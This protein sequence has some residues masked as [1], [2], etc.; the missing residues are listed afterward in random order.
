MCEKKIEDKIL[1]LIRGDVTDVETDAFVYH[2][3][4]NLELG[5]GFGGAIAVRGGP[6][7]KKELE[8]YLKENSELNVGDAIIS[9]AGN[10]KA[11]YIIHA[12]GPKFQE[13]NIKEKLSTTIL[14]AL[15]STAEKKDI[16]K[17][18]FPPLG[19]GFYGVPLDL[20]ADVLLTTVKQYLETN[21]TLK[22][23]EVVLQDN[24]EWIPFNKRLE[25]L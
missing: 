1:R 10:M 5:S 22:E 18:A 23:V 13:E 2:A 12:V 6:E 7:I 3:V 17:V 14:N 24:R 21:S 16:K 9:S 15:K 8:E 11:N 25:S 19:T 4:E 20:C